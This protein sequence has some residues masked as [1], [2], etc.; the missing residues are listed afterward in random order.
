MKFTLCP[1][2]GGAKGAY[3]L[4]F[5]DGCYKESTL[6]TIELF[7]KIKEETGISFKA[8]SFQTVNFLH[9]GLTS[10]WSDAIR[11][12]WYDIGGHSL[13]HC[14]CYNSKTP[15]ELLESDARLTLEKLKEIYPEAEI[16]TYATPGGGSDEEGRAPLKDY[17]VAV[18]NGNDA[19]NIPGK[20]DWYDVGTFTAT[21]DKKNED[22]KSHIDSVIE[23]GGWSV[24]INH[25]LTHKTEDKFHSQG[26]DTFVYECLYLKELA[27]KN[28]IWVASF[29]DAVKY[30]RKYEKSTL[31]VTE[32]KDT[33]TLELKSTLA[34]F[35][36]T[37]ITVR[38]EMDTPYYEICENEEIWHP[39]G[40]MYYDIKD[41]LRLKKL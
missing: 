19:L 13:D 4:T 16:I 12:G 35:A 37:P 31:V 10:M 33:I 40:I 29:N 1:Y 32:D 30:I 22:Y 23:K 28:E 17:Y 5:D 20:I 8:T 9:E 15:R 2:K 7:K 34:R 38:V 6:E 25:W 18:R 36:D 21:L 14:I 39:A 26:Y 27:A 24:Q 41:T 3:T 11:D